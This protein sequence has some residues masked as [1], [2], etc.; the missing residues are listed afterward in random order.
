M[1]AL[2]NTYLSL[3]ACAVCAFTVSGFVNPHR[4][5]CMEH[6]QNATLAGGVVVGAT[7]DM[8]LT[9]LGA[10]FAGALG[11]AVSTL[12]YQYVTPYLASR[13]KVTDTCGV[14]LPWPV[15]RC[16][17]STMRPQTPHTPVCT[18]Y[19]PETDNGTMS[20]SSGRGTRSSGGREGGH[21]PN[22][23]GDRWLP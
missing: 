16:M 8:M 1:R 2:V 15:T 21:Q 3:C 5:F 23:Q 6:I 10:V 14:W 9:P 11:G 12:G 7:A 13:W 18:R 17:T 20:P 22:R 19:S 4:K